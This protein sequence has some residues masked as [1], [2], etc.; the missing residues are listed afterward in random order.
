LRALLD[1][2]KPNLAVNVPPEIPFSG[3]WLRWL[4][5]DLAREIEH[6][7]QLNTDPL[8]FPVSCWYEPES[9]AVLDRQTQILWLAASQPSHLDVMQ[10]Q[11]EQT[12]REII[13]NNFPENY[14]QNS[15]TPIFQ[16]SQSEYKEIVRKAQKY[17][18]GGDIFQANLSLRFEARTN[19]SSWSIY[20]ALQRIDPSPFAS[21]WQTPW[22]R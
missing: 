15:A 17:I 8:P 20:R 2:Q 6:L 19:C 16:L 12:G 4:A 9:F 18:H 3:G 7:P 10:H 22:G 14:Q 5:Y 13:E 21:Y 1:S 11:L